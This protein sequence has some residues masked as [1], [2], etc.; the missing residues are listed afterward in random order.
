LSAWFS[1]SKNTITNLVT[2]LDFIAQLVGSKG[3][4]DAGSTFDFVPH[5]LSA[6]GLSGGYADGF[7]VT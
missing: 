6:F 4:P 3:P 2:Y 1:K 7:V 5:K